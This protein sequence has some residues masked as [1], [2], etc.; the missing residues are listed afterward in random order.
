MGPGSGERGKVSAKAHT[1]T[2]CSRGT[3]DGG[4]AD[5]LA[6][7]HPTVKDF[8]FRLSQASLVT[9]DSEPRRDIISLGLIRPFVAEKGLQGTLEEAGGLDG[10]LLRWSRCKWG[11]PARS[12][13]RPE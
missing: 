13:A 5:A 12:P 9:R 3:G 11:I 4:G 8:L 1:G 10:Q 2:D 7:T 6:P